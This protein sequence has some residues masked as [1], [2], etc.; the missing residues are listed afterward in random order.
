MADEVDE[1][2][3]VLEEEKTVEVEPIGPYQYFDT[4]NGEDIGKKLWCALKPATTLAIVAGTVDVLMYSKPKGY[5]A[6]LGRYAWISIPILGVTTA[7]VLTTNLSKIYR[8]E[9]DYWNW[10]LGGFGAGGVVGVYTGRATSGWL[11]GATFATAAMIKKY[12]VDNNI[13]MIP[14]GKQALG[15]IRYVRH[16]YSL[17]SYRPGNYTVGP[18]GSVGPEVEPDE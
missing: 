3:S 15:T 9:E 17:T 5:L 1:E 8:K 11:W 4:P 16:D 2:H 14:Q 18:I 7:F 6:A 13:I 10:A 12:A